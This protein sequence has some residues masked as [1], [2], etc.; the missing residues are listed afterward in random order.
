AQSLAAAHGNQ[1][2]DVEHLL[3][4]LLDQKGG[5]VPSIL[6]RADVAVDPLRKRVTEEINRLPKISGAATQPDQIHVTKRL[7][8]LF[9]RAE[10]EAKRLK[11]EY[12]SVEHFLL[13]MT[14][15]QGAAGKLLRD[16]G[17]TRDRMMK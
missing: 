16:A 5:L 6:A 15:D 11:D 7:S 3:L 10:D 9:D 8:Q 17:A 14:E 1:Q 13:A 2:I 4:A 12:V